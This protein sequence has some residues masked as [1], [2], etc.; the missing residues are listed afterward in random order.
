MKVRD[1][2]AKNLEKR[3]KVVVVYISLKKRGMMKNENKKF[4]NIL[5]N[6]YLITK[7]SWLICFNIKPT[8]SIQVK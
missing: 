1:V 7:L 5:N 4:F 2:H 8:V 6:N 3:K